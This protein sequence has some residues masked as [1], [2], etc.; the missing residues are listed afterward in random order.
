MSVEFSEMK[1]GGKGWMRMPM[2]MR[3]TLLP[4]S[5]KMEMVGGKGQG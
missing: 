3:V 5:R 2:M 4:P 1:L